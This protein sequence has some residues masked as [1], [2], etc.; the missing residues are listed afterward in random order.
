MPRGGR[1]I[2]LG[3]DYVQVIGQATPEETLVSSL[4]EGLRGADVVLTDSW[5]QE[6]FD[7]AYQVTLEALKSASADALVIPCPPF[8]VPREVHAEV[9]ASK[10]F[11][12]Y[13]QK[14]GLYPVHKTILVSLLG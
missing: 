13:E 3:L 6:H 14:S 8:N 2:H 1:C 7:P 9:I 12:G 5:P 4:T 10:Y 11:A